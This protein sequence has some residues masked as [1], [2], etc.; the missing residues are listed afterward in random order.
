MKFADY[1][2]ERPD[3][4]ALEQ[5]FD[6]LLDQFQ[7]ASD[8]NQQ[9]EVME[10]INHLR[11]GFESMAEIA[12]IRHTIDTNDEQYKKEQDFFDETRPIYTG[13]TTKFYQALVD[14]KF[15]GQLEE[16]WGKQLFNLAELT[17]KTFDP[18][19]IEDLQQENKLV[20]KYVKL[21][22]AAKV[23][24]EGEERNLSQLEP[25]QLSTDRNMR[26][27]ANE[28]K[29]GYLAEHEQELDDIY[30]QLVRVRTKMAQKLGYENF[31]ELGYARM[32]R[33]DYDPK[34]VA[35][36]RRQ[37]KKH[38][39]PVATK[40]KE[41]Q[42]KRIGVDTLTYYDEPFEFKTGNAKPKGNADWILNNAK[43]MYAEMSSDTDE[44][45][46]F[47]TENGLLDLVTKKGKAGGGYCTFID[48]YKAPFIFSNFNGT[49]GDVD[50]LTH[51]GGHAFQM[52]SSRE[53]EIPE[54]HIPTSEAA[55]I[56]SMSMEFFA[57][58]WAESFFKEDTEK[59]KFSHLSDALLFIPYGVAVDEFQHFVYENP[60]V[61]PAERKQV[62]RDIERKYQPHKDY[63]EN[64]YLERGGFW[65]KQGHIYEVPFYYIDY[66]L[67]Q[68]CAFQFWK[69]MHEDR[70]TA[71]KDYD[72]LCRRGGSQ[73]FLNLVREANL[74]S[75]FEDGSIESVIGD[76]ESYLDGIED[77]KL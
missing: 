15:R 53:Y 63:T 1:V 13:L 18:K 36:F 57:W 51:E 54:Y 37:V 38:I 5:R 35:N 47:M 7:G 61:S 46:T 59:Y 6:E 23:E 70:E 26:K 9:N 62:W 52:Y 58:P 68:V 42:R 12:Q 33:S 48:Q 56:H 20:T 43:K 67:A 28:A 14:S 24:F 30:D 19:I 72:R 40:L 77:T 71:W 32:Q 21:I 34:M 4:K 45:F 55:E 11:S 65:Q 29:F 44:F 27:R 49:S 3:I 64:D 76:I 66:T 8:V 60:Q 31:V 2:Y 69:K 16:K 41:R 74:I 25:F 10:K 73:S 17:L 39:V 75:P 22:A 50:V